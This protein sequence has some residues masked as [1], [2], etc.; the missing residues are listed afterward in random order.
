MHGVGIS[1][2]RGSA[3]NQVMGNRIGTTQ[4]G[5][6]P[7]GNDCS[8][9]RITSSATDIIIGRGL[10]PLPNGWGGAGERAFSTARD[11]PSRIH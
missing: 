1:P 5:T 6:A 7:L 10:G 9:I 2:G 8:G 3:G 11:G 4:E